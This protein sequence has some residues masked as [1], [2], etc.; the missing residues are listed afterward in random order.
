MNIE[1]SKEVLN[2][3]NLNIPIIALE[4]TIISHGM[5]YPKNLET[6]KNCEQLVRDNGCCPATIAIIKGKI[7]IGLEY[8]ELEYLAKQGTKI[9]KVSRRDIPLVIAKSQDGATTVAATM[10]LANLANIKFFAT[11]GIGGVHRG[12]EKTFDIS[13]DLDEFSKTNVLVVSAGVKSI[14]DL[15]KTMEYLETK[16]VLILGYKTDY[17]PEFYTNG[18]TIKLNYRIDDTNLIA[19]IFKEKNNLKLSSGMLVC[20]PIPKEYEMDYYFINNNINEAIKKMDEENIT[21]KDA[22]PYLLKTICDLTQ[23]KSLESNI[24]L[25]YNNVILATKIAKDYYNLK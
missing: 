21:G 7:K 23:G 24:K 20:N 14:L 13:A 4:S 16:G 12:A 1:Y 5:P 6:A 18:K 22:T 10:I 25:V 2:A 8:E 11:G 9:L 19:N 3:I 15:P 17:L